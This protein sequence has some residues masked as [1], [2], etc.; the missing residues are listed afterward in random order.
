MKRLQNVTKIVEEVLRTD[1]RT[2][3]SDGLLY[4]KVLEAIGKEREINYLI[5]PTTRLLLDLE[6]LK[7]PSMETV[8]RCRRKA[9]EKCPELRASEEVESFRAEKEAVFKEWAKG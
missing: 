7:L 6:K 9:Q 2:R 8:G 3:N 1:E 4:I 5:M